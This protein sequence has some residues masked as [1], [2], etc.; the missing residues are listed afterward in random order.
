[1]SHSNH[2]YD[3]DQALPLLA[4]YR[5]AELP[6]DA[7]GRLRRHLMD[8]PDCRREASEHR[9][10]SRW[11]KHG[12]PSGAPAGF[13]AKVASLA[14]VGVASDGSVSGGGSRFAI[15]PLAVAAAAVALIGLAVA[16][17]WQQQPASDGLQ[18]E[19]LPLVLEELK[20]LNEAAEQEA[21]DGNANEA[22]DESTDQ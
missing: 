21:A 14:Q 22:N 6:E 12:L 13:A 7:A 9:N 15:A 5:D 11:F 20:A 3:C 17:G 2:D 4:R 8:C 1:M 10:L 19:S 18:A 16:L